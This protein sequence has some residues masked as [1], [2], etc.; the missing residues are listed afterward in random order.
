[1]C[2]YGEWAVWALDRGMDG[3][4][5]HDLDHSEN[6]QNKKQLALFEGLT[7]ST[8]DVASMDARSCTM[9]SLFSRSSADGAQRGDTK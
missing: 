4:N 5:R 9:V 2:G 1:M 7:Q 8:F 6:H 3:L